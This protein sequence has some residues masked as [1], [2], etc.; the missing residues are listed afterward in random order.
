MQN[1]SNKSSQYETVLLRSE[2]EGISPN[3]PRWNDE[4]MNCIT[5][6]KIGAILN[7]SKFTS[8]R[9][10]FLQMVTRNK[11]T[12]NKTSSGIMQ[13]GV[14]TESLVDFIYVEHTGHKTMSVNFLKHPKYPFIGTTPDRIVDGHLVEY[15]S[16]VNRN[17]SDKIPEEYMDQCLLQME[18]TG[19]PFCQFVEAK[20]VCLL[21]E[22]EDS[23]MKKC[24]LDYNSHQKIKDNIYY[25]SVNEKFYRL[26]RFKIHPLIKRNEEWFNSVL[27]TLSSFY[28][29]V[30]LARQRL[31]SSSKDVPET[32][33]GGTTGGTTTETTGGGGMFNLLGKVWN[34]ARSLFTNNNISPNVSTDESSISYNL[35]YVESEMEKIKDI[36]DELGILTDFKTYSDISS[37]RNIYANDPFLTWC[38]YLQQIGAMNTDPSTKNTE[39][40]QVFK[41][42]EQRF[43]NLCEK[44]IRQCAETHHFTIEK[45]DSSVFPCDIVFNQTDQYL[46]NNVDVILNPMFKN[47]TAKFYGTC[48]AVIKLKVLQHIMTHT[49]NH[50]DRKLNDMIEMHGDSYVPVSFR[51]TTL[52]VTSPKHYAYNIGSVE[53]Y[54]AHLS[55]IND[56]LQNVNVPTLNLALLF[57]RKYK[58]PKGDKVQMGWFDNVAIVEFTSEIKENTNK[59]FVIYDHIAKNGHLWYNYYYNA[60]SNYFEFNLPSE[61]YLY[62]EKE[63]LPIQYYPNM[64]NTQD[65]PYSYFKQK[66]SQYVGEVTQISYVTPAARNPDLSLNKLTVDDSSKIIST[67]KATPTSAK[68]ISNICQAQFSQFS[69]KLKPFPKE[70][71]DGTLVPFIFDVEIMNSLFVE[72]FETN[73]CVSTEKS[74]II[75]LSIMP[76]NGSCNNFYI[77]KMDINSEVNMVKRLYEYI[78]NV[79]VSNKKT[80]SDAVLVHWGSLDVTEFQ[81][82]CDNHCVSSQINDDEYKKMIETTRLSFYDLLANIK[83]SDDPIGIHGCYDHKLYNITNALL[84]MGKITQTWDDEKDIFANNGADVSAVAYLYYHKKKLTETSSTDTN[85]ADMI[86]IDNEYDN[87]LFDLDDVSVDEKFKQVL[88]HNVKDVL[89]LN[90]LFNFFVTNNF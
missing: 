25:N 6:S 79:C 63:P 24:V 76:I 77:D 87:E 55:M 11:P 33:T 72:D 59:C 69:G 4:R 81:K 17:I 84:N 67:L 46:K 66:F 20:L 30:I 47:D 41:D 44:H 15:K 57:G 74:Y 13:H 73:T 85:S 82:M 14:D 52:T 35:E 23:D 88:K 31:N 61:D 22:E 45:V 28:D 54:K 21:N 71:C 2:T 12:N 34:G 68:F 42:K 48:S 83:N 39:F 3:D 10:V 26:E 58:T 40:I 27:P 9:Q 7:K 8:K 64:C 65:A 49:E 62:M 78:E 51:F 90:E 29:K 16:V 80:I 5:G 75:C 53:Y 37:L 18:V 36:L 70:L 1:K 56:M 89:M 50:T 38:K 86:I 32:T 19:M 60:D 43:I